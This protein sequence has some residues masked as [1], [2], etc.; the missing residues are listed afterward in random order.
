MF[1]M[2]SAMECYV[3]A[4]N[5]LGNSVAPGDFKD[6]MDAQALRMVAPW[7]VIGDRQ[8][9]PLVGYGRFFLNVQMYWK[10]RRE[11]IERISE[12]HDVSKHRNTIYVGGRHRTDPPEGFYESLGVPNDAS[13]RALYW[14]MA[15]IILQDDPKAPRSSRGQRPREEM[16]L[17]ET[18]VPEFRDFMNTTARMALQ[19][20]RATIQLKEEEFRRT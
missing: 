5:A 13:S 20:A 17:L 6:V 16:Q 19:D 11:L 2:D 8:R 7:N 1:S 9:Q 4:L 14:P 12:Q 15:E 10:S 3:F 18:L